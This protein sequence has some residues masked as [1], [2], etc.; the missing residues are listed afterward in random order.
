MADEPE[1]VKDPTKK[2]FWHF[3]N[4]GLIA[5]TAAIP[6]L[7]GW[8]WNRSSTAISNFMEREKKDQERLFKLEEDVKNLAEQSNN[9]AVWDALTE[10]RNRITEQDVELRVM[11]KLFEREFGRAAPLPKP[12][13]THVLKDFVLPEPMPEVAKPTPLKPDQYRIEKEKLHPVE[14]K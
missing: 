2:S 1:V 12:T 10:A 7:V 6:A 8:A 5:I 14:K 11:Q 13:V 4:I 9:R 3:K